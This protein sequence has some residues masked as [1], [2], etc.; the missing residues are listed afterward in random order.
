MRD[1]ATSAC[2]QLAGCEPNVIAEAAKMNEGMG[3]K[4]SD[5]NFGCPAKK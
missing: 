5:L 4:I 3:A 1:D 2:V